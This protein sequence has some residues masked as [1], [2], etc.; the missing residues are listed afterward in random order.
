MSSRSSLPSTPQ[1]SLSS[2]YM[3][4][5]PISLDHDDA[6]ESIAFLERGA[7]EQYCYLWAEDTRQL[8]LEWWKTTTYYKTKCQN[9]DEAKR[10]RFGGKKTADVWQYYREA[11]TAVKGIMEGIPQVVCSRCN[12]YIK[13]PGTG[14]GTHYMQIYL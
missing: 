11:A 10:F 2:G 1:S 3:P 4:T 14:L 6:P 5:N 13:Y 7:K 8:F 12:Q 9:I